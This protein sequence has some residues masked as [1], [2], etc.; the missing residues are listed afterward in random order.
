MKT[1]FSKISKIKFTL[2]KILILLLLLLILIKLLKVSLHHHFKLSLYACEFCIFQPTVR[3]STGDTIRLHFAVPL[4]FPCDHSWPLWKAKRAIR[5]KSMLH[6]TCVQCCLYLI[7]THNRSNSTIK[8]TCVW[9][10]RLPS[11]IVQ[12]YINFHTYVLTIKNLYTLWDVTRHNHQHRV[13]ARLSK[14]WLN[15]EVRFTKEPTSLLISK[16]TFKQQVNG[17]QVVNIDRRYKNII[18]YYS[19]N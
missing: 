8:G 17:Y 9:L 18:N 10:N 7:W 11:I 5:C 12:C 6:V 15:Y 3:F 13:F 16:Q 4:S 1:L 2:F 14:P 19:E